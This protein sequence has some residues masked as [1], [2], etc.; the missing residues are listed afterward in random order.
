[1]YNHRPAKRPALMATRR[2][3][4]PKGRPDYSPTYIHQ[5]A[6]VIEH[7]GIKAPILIDERRV[8]HSGMAL[9]LAACHL[10]LPS[11]PVVW[12]TRPA[13]RHAAFKGFGQ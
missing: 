3:R 6:S 2:L 10:G 7:D 4:L 5:L 9:Y 8:I 13:P 1:M 11:V 12:L